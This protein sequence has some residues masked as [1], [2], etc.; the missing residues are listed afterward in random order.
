MKEVIRNG[1]RFPLDENNY[2]PPRELGEELQRLNQE[3]L[4][5][6]NCEA[7]EV[8]IAEGRARKETS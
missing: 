8:S 7:C 6:K 2:E 1:L 3:V 5:T 4:D